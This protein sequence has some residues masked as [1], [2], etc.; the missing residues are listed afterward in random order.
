M[1]FKRFCAF[2]I[3]VFIAIICA[4]PLC[5]CIMVLLK[6]DLGV[7][8]GVDAIWGAIFCKDCFG[9]RSIGKRILVYQVID[10]KT[11]QIARPFKCVLRNLFCF[12]GIID[13]IPMFSRS[14]GLRLGDYVA[15][16]QVISYD[17]T[18]KGA[19]LIEAVLTVVC[20][21]AVLVAIN[22]LLTHYASSLGLF[23]HL[24]Q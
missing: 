24:Y 16:T 8:M 18:L 10:G 11:G 3:D 9:G 4:F 12:L 13:V 2:V 7:S 21:F 14:R 19:R 5:V 23:G 6:I 15:H 1:E 22:M 20:V 17:K